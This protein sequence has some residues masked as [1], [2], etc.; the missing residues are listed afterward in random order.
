V[1]INRIAALF[2]VTRQRI[3]TLVRKRNG[4]DMERDVELFLGSCQRAVS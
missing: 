4:S 1:R 3:S 2:G